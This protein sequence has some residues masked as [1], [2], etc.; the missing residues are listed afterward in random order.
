MNIWIST[1]SSFTVINT[2]TATTRKS[3][4]DLPHPHPWKHRLWGFTYFSGKHSPWCS[5]KDSPDRLCCYA[6]PILGANEVFQLLTYPVIQWSCCCWALLPRTR[7]PYPVTSSLS[8]VWK[9]KWCKLGYRRRSST[10]E[11]STAD[12]SATF[13]SFMEIVLG[14]VCYLLWNEMHETSFSAY[15]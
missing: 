8:A 4:K 7:L 9:P 6:L 1:N 15:I 3:E 12:Y 13:T 11:P 10:T 2:R 5:W 14:G